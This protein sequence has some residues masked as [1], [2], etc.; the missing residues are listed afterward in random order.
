MTAA[1]V[2]LRVKPSVHLGNP[3]AVVMKIISTIVWPVGR[4]GGLKE[5]TLEN[6]KNT[7]QSAQLKVQH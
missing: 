4:N 1:T 5:L 6:K 7:R 3:V 2:T